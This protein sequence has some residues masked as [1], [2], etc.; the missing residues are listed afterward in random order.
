LGS[1]NENI[2]IIKQ[3]VQEQG[4]TF[5]VLR[6]AGSALYYS[7]DMAGAISP[8]PRDYII[9]QNG[10]FAY[11][12]VE[13]NINEMTLVIESLLEN[14]T[15]VDDPTKS[16]VQPKYF[17]LGQNYPN[18]FNP[19]TR[20]EYSVSE[21]AFVDIAVY[22]AVGRKIKQLV[23]QIKPKGFYLQEWNGLDN[24]SKAVSSGVYFYKMKVGDEFQQKKMMLLR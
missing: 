6:D 2:D 11:A 22:N 8:F 3:F 23:Q 4:I 14:R 5:P 20:F 17:T 13:Y 16:E 19:T 7:Y 12:N 10:V 24:E 9:D 18:P 1:S 15:R 21:P